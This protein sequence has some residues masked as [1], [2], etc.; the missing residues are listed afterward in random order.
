MKNILFILILSLLLWSCNDQYLELPPTTKLGESLDFF[1]TKNGLETFT[2]SFYGYVDQQ[3][4]LDDFNSDNCEHI[5]N[6]P[7]IRRGVYTVPT[8]LGSGNWSWTQLRNINYF[9]KMSAQATI[10]SDVKNPYIAVAKFF[11]ARFYFEK[12]KLFGDVPWYSGPLNTSDEEALYKSRDPRTMVMDSILN[13]LNYAIQYLPVTKAKNKLSKWTAL[14]LKSRVCLY[15]GTWRKYH[16]EVSLP[17][18]TEL[19]NLC[20]DAS[21]QIMDAGVYSVF[22]SGNKNGDYFELFQPKNA[23]TE[24]VILAKSFADGSYFYYSPMFT[25]TSNGNYGA[26]NSLVSSYLLTNGKPVNPNLADTASYFTEFQNRDP[27]LAQSILYPGYI[28]VGNTAKA[29]TDFAE[30][31]TGYQII[32]RVGP[33]IED[34]GGDTRDAIIF[35]YGEVL[36]NYAEALAELGSLTQNDLNKTINLLRG[37]VGIPALTL[38]VTLDNAM[39]KLYQNTSDPII[40]EV[41]RERRIE[42]AFEGFRREDLQRWKEGQIFRSQQVGIYI[43]GIHNLIDLDNDGKPDLYVLLST[44]TAPTNKIPGVQYFKLSNVNGLTNGT[45]GRII[46]FISVLPTFKDWEYLN[47]I[48]KEE[49]TLNPKLVQNPEWDKL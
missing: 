9:I 21:E 22:S 39:A 34:Q 12:I 35:R 29:V 48:P 38:P 24:E 17:K 27:R 37:R 23:H 40:L 3:V 43:S 15:E 30:N 26:T 36:L 7:A 11:R 47:P 42:L 49:L 2:N 5:G 44:E 8:A 6:P 32:K 46:Q 1:Q 45:K 33:P 18:S 13:D 31:R 10:S 16:K 14:A 41:R 19:L 25:S 4:L 28:R 20:V